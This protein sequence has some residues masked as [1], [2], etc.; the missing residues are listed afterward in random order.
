MKTYKVLLNSETF[1]SV[2]IYAEQFQIEH[3]VL[4]FYR[5]INHKYVE[6]AAVYNWVYVKEEEE[7][8]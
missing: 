1:S 5:N 3:G 6:C 4:V 8:E 2:H 7:E